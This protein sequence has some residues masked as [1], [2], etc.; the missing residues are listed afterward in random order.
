MAFDDEKQGTEESGARLVTVKYDI[1]RQ[2]FT[3]DLSV[4]ALNSTTVIN[5]KFQIHQVLISC[6]NGAGVL[7]ALNSTRITVTFDSLTDATYDC[8]IGVVDFDGESSVGLI[9][10][11]NLLGVVC[12]QGDEINVLSSGTDS[13]NTLYVTIIYR[14]LS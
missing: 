3:K 4:G 11:D 9:A 12:E 6:R 13:S 2:E 10:G 8:P 7:T 14:L 1:D 5:D